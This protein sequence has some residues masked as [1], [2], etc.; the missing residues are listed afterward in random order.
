M[1]WLC[2]GKICLYGV[3]VSRLAEMVE[4]SCWEF[5]TTLCCDIIKNGAILNALDSCKRVRSRQLSWIVNVQRMYVSIK[6]M[7]INDSR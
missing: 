2:S 4:E 3:T 7:T 1:S 5:I 6:V